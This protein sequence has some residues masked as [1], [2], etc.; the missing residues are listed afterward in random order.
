MTIGSSS[1]TVILARR[2]APARIVDNFIVN[3]QLAKWETI[4]SERRF[5]NVRQKDNYIDEVMVAVPETIG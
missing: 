3:F 4:I 2:V 1:A 5:Y